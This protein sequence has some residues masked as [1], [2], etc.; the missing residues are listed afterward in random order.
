MTLIK[1]IFFFSLS[2]SSLGVF[3][4]RRR[5]D[6]IKSQNKFILVFLLSVEALLEADP[7]EF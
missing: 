7:I 2:L 1:N 5:S 3:Y 6:C 4:P